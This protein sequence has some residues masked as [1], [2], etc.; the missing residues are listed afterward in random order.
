MFYISLQ[1]NNKIKKLFPHLNKKKVYTVIEHY[2]NACNA[3]YKIVK[4]KNR[5]T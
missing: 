3:L 2:I 5:N 1:Y 4:Y